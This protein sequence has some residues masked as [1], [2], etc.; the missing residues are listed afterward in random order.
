MQQPTNYE[1]GIFFNMPIKEYHKDGTLSNTSIKQL[2]K[3]PSVYW[4]NAPA[5]NPLAEYTEPSKA[6]QDSDLFHMLLLE[7]GRFAE[8]YVVMP[9][10]KP[11]PGQRIIGKSRYDMLLKAVNLTKSKPRTGKLFQG[12]LCE[13]SFIAR[14]SATGLL[15][16]ARP[17]YIKA[18]VVVDYKAHRSVA[19]HNV[20]QDI[21]SYG[22]DIQCGLGVTVV[23]EARQQLLNKQ[24]GVFCCAPDGSY[25]P[26]DGYM[27]TE[28]EAWLAGFMAAGDTPLRFV[29]AFQE[30]A[31]PYIGATKE[32]G[33]DIFELGM[34]KVR[35]ALDVYC[36]CLKEFGHEPWPDNE[37]V[38][39][40]I[41]LDDLPQR[42][43]YT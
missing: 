9:G 30:K 38:I 17:D 33:S 32:M 13:V 35:E 24:A 43:F 40:L 14:D 16:A 26:A 2:R 39:E 27:T 3:S 12:G 41:T 23:S 1:P 8:N 10:G 18:S 28:Q 6:M 5:L 31:P 34:A 36:A 22:Y 20:R 19:E 7:P 21:V 37:D 42:V 25:W 4:W 11:L 29:Y 15:L